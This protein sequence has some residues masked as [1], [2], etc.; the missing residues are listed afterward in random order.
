M[1]PPCDP[2]GQF[3]RAMRLILP[4]PCREELLKQVELVVAANKNTFA[5]SGDFMSC[6]REG[7]R[8]R[9]GGI[10][11]GEGLGTDSSCHA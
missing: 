1:T 6:G 2:C 9:G 8:T 7:E 3:P 5:V 10:S 4:T 11:W